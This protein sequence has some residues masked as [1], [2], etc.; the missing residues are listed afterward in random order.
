MNISKELFD[1]IDKLLYTANWAAGKLDIE[2]NKRRSIP[3]WHE[4]DCLIESREEFLAV[5]KELR[6][7]NEL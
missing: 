2:M 7:L 1:R 4:L 5:R 6:A 3:S